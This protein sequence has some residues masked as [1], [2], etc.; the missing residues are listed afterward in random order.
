MKTSIW[1]RERLKKMEQ[2]RL[3]EQ[4]KE[5]LSEAILSRAIER[6]E[7]LI[8]DD[9]EEL[10]ESEKRLMGFIGVIEGRL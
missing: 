8:Q 3:R 9:L 5:R 2:N 7:R 6:E 4:E 1:V 10:E